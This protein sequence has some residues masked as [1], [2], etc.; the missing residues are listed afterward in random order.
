VR[1]VA[2]AALMLVA[3]DL[4]DAEVGALAR[5]VY[6]K[7]GD[8]AARGSAQG[9]QVSAANAQHGLTVPLHDAA[10]RVLAITP[11]GASASAAS[12]SASQPASSPAR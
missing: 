5:F 11:A 3:A 9:L 10:A 2:T 8:F 12:T 1:T 6:D 4:S 7:G